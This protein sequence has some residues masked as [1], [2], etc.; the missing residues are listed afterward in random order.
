MKV[1]LIRLIY[2]ERIKGERFTIPTPPPER[3]FV[4]TDYVNWYKELNV[5][6]RYGSKSEFFLN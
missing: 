1:L 2:G 5:G 3:E 6:C 4:F